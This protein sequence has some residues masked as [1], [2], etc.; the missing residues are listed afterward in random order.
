MRTNVRQCTAVKRVKTASFYRERFR[1]GKFFFKGGVGRPKFSLFHKNG[2]GI[3]IYQFRKLP[4]TSLMRPCVSVKTLQTV[5]LSEYSHR[6]YGSVTE[7]GVGEKKNR[8]FCHVFKY[9]PDRVVWLGIELGVAVVSY[10]SQ[11]SRSRYKLRPSKRVTK[12]LLY[13]ALCRCLGKCS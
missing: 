13:F 4:F 10:S 5:P 1:L 9:R 3:F 2:W 11:L 6:R 7:G 8:I 12:Q